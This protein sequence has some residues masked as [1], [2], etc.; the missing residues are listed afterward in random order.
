MFKP[1]RVQH[2]AYI[3]VRLVG[4]SEIGMP[5]R[6]EFYSGEKD[7][8]ESKFLELIVTDINYCLLRITDLGKRLITSSN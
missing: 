8:I 1:N 2:H 6:Y 3:A 4:T 5:M 7:A